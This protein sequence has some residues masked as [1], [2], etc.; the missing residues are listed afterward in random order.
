MGRIDRLDLDLGWSSCGLYYAESSKCEL[1]DFHSARLA[2]QVVDS[3]GAVIRHAKVLL[4]DHDGALAEQMQDD[5]QGRFS[6]A[7]SFAGT[8]QLVVSSEGFTPYRR[9]VHLE[10]TSD[11]GGSSSL[12]VQLGLRGNCGA[13]DSR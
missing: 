13:T 9:T 4:I 12:T 3:G 5:G 11:S 10:P 2:G 6:S 1:S 7:L 8:Y